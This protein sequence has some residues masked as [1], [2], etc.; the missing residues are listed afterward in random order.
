M[1]VLSLEF[2]A[3][4]IVAILIVTFMARRKRKGPVIVYG[5]QISFTGQKLVT[6]ISVETPLVCLLDEGKIYG[7]DFKEKTPPDLPHNE[8]CQCRLE[9][10]INRSRDW[11]SEKKKVMEDCINSDLGE[12][13]RTEYRYYK[14]ALLA[15]HKEADEQTRK[16]YKELQENISISDE[17]KERVKL[18]IS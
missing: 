2:L 10:S 5:K 18:Q 11:F 4:L 15:H 14:Y 17:F 6:P 12:L 7:E 13:S 1:Q 8:H 9:I 16:E 3:F